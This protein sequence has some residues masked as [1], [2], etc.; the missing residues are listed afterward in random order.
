V[1]G[2]CSIPERQGVLCGPRARATKMGGE[3]MEL[4]LNCAALLMA[5]TKQL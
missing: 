2:R 1:S 5:P 3:A 4:A